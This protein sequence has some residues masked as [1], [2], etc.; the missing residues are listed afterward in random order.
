MAVKVSKNLRRLRKAQ[1]KTQEQLAAELHVTRQAISNWEN[2]KTQ[3]DL[4]SLLLLAKIF[5]VE[6]EELIYGE[7][8]Q[9]GTEVDPD[10]ASAKVRIALGVVG[11]VFVGV[12]LVLIFLNFWQDFPL[13]L[14]TVFSVLPLLFGQAFAVYV[15]CKRQDEVV[16]RECGAILWCIGII[17]TIALINSV[18]DIHCGF[19][20]CL[21]IDIVLCLPVFYL[22]R[23]V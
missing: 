20:N 11:A 2:D 3:P 13:P 19:Q 4:E 16:W 5:H 9:V 10:R 21:L 8:R 17:S 12:G 7:K 18:F 15:F 14:Q 6:I 23:A 1:N 22:L